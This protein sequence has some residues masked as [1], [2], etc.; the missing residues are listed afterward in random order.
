MKVLLTE[1]EQTFVRNVARL[2]FRNNRSTNTHN[3]RIGK[4]SDE[5]TDVQG[6]GGELAFCRMAGIEPDLSIEPGVRP[7]V[8]CVLSDGRTVDVKTSFRND[9]PLRAK[10]K[11]GA[12]LPDLYALMVGAF[13][14]FRFAGT[15]ESARL[16]R[17]ENWKKTKY[18]HAFVM[19]QKLLDRKGV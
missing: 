12:T 11:P 15:I 9:A 19:P 17:Q 10:P 4:Q 14:A 16:I 7:A 8:D 6:F 3:G 5:A 1:S 18:D 2:R 13:P